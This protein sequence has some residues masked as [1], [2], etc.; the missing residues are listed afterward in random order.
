MS[1]STPAASASGARADGGPTLVATPDDGIRLTGPL[2]W[3]EGS[4]P[5]LGEGPPTGYTAAQLSHPRHLIEIHDGLRAELER[6]R[7][8]VRQVRA[9]ALSIGAA[10]SIINTMAM[11][12]NNWTLGAFCESYCRIVTGHHTLEDRGV[13]P[14]LRRSE[15]AVGPVLDRLEAEHEVIAEVID[16]LDRALV[17]LV[18]TDGGGT[19]ALDELEAQV[20]LLTD[21]LRS[22]LAYEERELIGPLARH[23][24]T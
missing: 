23:G 20:D 1:G 3:N 2:A 8:V 24:L 15:P 5:T 4:R 18:A 16:A 9:G 22:H 10:R 14:H 11:R 6:V 17:A 19:R 21:T 7:D 12:Q 13:F